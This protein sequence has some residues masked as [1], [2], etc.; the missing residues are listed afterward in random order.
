MKN[1]INPETG[2]KV[3]E[4]KNGLKTYKKCFV[5]AEAVDWMV[6]H[7]QL[8][9]RE[10]A[11]EIGNILISRCTLLLTSPYHIHTH[12]PNHLKGYN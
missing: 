3:L 2:L 11:V 10:L 12:T 7:L 5:G 1:L 8:D 6:N 4:R 9:S